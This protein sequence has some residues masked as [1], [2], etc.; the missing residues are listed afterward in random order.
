M[1]YR[2]VH[3]EPFVALG[4][5]HLVDAALLGEAL[6]LCKLRAALGR[7]ET[8]AFVCRDGAG[9]GIWR[10]STNTGGGLKLLPDLLPDC[11]IRDDISQ[12]WERLCVS[13]KAE[14][15]IP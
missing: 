15:S 6:D 14:K 8:N 12:H 7:E 5:G 11:T 3:R 4:L 1:P 9:G 13:D 2:A 10:A